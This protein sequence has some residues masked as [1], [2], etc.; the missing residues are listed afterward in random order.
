[1]NRRDAA[2]RGVAEVDRDETRIDADDRY[3]SVVDIRDDTDGIAN[4]KGPRL[5]RYVGSGKMVVHEAQGS[6]GKALADHD[7]RL[8]IYEAIDHHPTVAGEPLK[9]PRCLLAQLVERR[10]ALERAAHNLQLRQERCVVAMARTFIGH[11]DHEIPAGAKGDRIHCRSSEGNIA[12]DLGAGRGKHVRGDVCPEIDHG[13]QGKA[14][15]A[16][17]DAEVLSPG[18]AHDRVRGNIRDQHEALRLNGSRNVNRFRVA[19]D[20][21]DSQIR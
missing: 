17:V 14:D 11:L 1:M 18:V 3:G 6:P 2:Q 4:V 15:D 10:R 7:A 16:A 12:D 5:T 8:I 9:R 19:T 13:I 20:D 21:F